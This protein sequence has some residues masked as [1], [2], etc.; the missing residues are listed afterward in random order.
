[1]QVL[2]QDLA[3]GLRDRLTGLPGVE[4]VRSR[5]EQWGVQAIDGG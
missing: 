5:L 3:D 2:R 1:M 4:A